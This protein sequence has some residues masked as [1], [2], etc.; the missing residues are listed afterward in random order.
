[1]SFAGSLIVRNTLTLEVRGNPEWNVDDSRLEIIYDETADV[2]RV[3]HPVRIQPDELEAQ[4]LDAFTHTLDSENTTHTAAIDVGANNTLTIVTSTGDTAVYHTRPE[5]EQFHQYSERV[6]ELQAELPEDRHS[7]QRIRRLY[8][9]R[10]RK[11]DHSRNA[12][13]KHAT[14]WLLERNVDT[15][16][17]GDFRDVLSTHWSASVNEKTHAL[18]PWATH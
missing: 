2:F 15:V 18:E 5:F 17:V 12:A 8:A 16:Y 13:V 3:K 9:E 10:T 1:M 6:A 7:S 14:E 11:R 4:Q